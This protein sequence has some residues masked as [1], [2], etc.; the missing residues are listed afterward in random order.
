M[1]HLSP[2]DLTLILLALEEYATGLGA[3]F[4]PDESEQARQLARR[5]SASKAVHVDE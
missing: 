1:A 4:G 2:A 3:A 5:L